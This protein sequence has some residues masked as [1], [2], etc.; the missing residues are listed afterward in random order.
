MLMLYIVLI[1]LNK[2]YA[3]Y[4]ACEGS[5][6][7]R[8]FSVNRPKYFMFTDVYVTVDTARA[9]VRHVRGV[10]PNKAADFTGP[11]FCICLLYT[12]PSPRD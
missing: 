6:E 7:A 8:E 12:S 1:R 3:T 5:T 2:L 11:P 4:Y 10:Q 9:G